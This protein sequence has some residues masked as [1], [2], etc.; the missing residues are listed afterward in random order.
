MHCN[1]ERDADRLTDVR[2]D[3][4]IGHELAADHEPFFCRVATPD[5]QTETDEPDR[6]GPA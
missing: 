1:F 2:F 6:V 3:V 4:P 5:W